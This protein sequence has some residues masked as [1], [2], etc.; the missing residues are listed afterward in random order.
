MPQCGTTLP[1]YCIFVNF[2][3]IVIFVHWE[4]DVGSSLEES[5]QPIYINFR[6]FFLTVVEFHSGVGALVWPPPPT[7]TPVESYH[8]PPLLF[9]LPQKH[10]KRPSTKEGSKRTVNEMNEINDFTYIRDTCFHC[11]PAAHFI[12]RERNERK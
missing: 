1:I 11:Q 3:Q 5:L 7:H 10:T 8:G 12:R 2:V 6:S 9:L 4:A